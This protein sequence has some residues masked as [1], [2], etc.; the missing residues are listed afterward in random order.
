MPATGCAAP[1]A[2]WLRAKARL[3]V[4]APSAVAVL[5]GPT[6]SPID[7]RE[8]IST[9]MSAAAASTGMAT[10]AFGCPA[11]VFTGFPLSVVPVPRARHHWTQGR[12]AG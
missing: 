8:P 7:D 1:Q 3:M 2:S 12:Q 11:K 4:A 5:I 9:A 6:N 10:L